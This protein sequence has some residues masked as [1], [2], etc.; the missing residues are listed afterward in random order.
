MSETV[1]RV[2]CACVGWLA[3]R[4]PPRRRVGCR[5]ER[6]SAYR[7]LRVPNQQTTLL[8]NYGHRSVIYATTSRNRSILLFRTMETRPPVGTRTH[9]HTAW[10]DI[11]N[12][13]TAAPSRRPSSSARLPS[14]VPSS[15]ATCDAA[16]SLPPT[17][18]APADRPQHQRL[19]PHHPQHLPSCSATACGTSEWA[20]FLGTT[21]ARDFECECRV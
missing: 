5:S 9:D 18:C 15:N 10:S 8:I 19:A 6:G 4:S 13:C 17:T 2:A 21:S 3:C 7:D 16:T 20:T 14:T 1:E 12:C 11:R